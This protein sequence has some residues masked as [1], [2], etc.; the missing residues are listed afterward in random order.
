MN[1]KDLRIGNLVYYFDKI[2]EI[3]SLHPQNDDVNDEIPFHCISGIPITTEWL[4][5]LGFIKE[6]YVNNFY[7]ENDRT[8]YLIYLEKYLEGEDDYVSIEYLKIPLRQKIKIKYVHQ[9]QNLFYSIR[10]YELSVS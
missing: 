8:L 2:I 1:P 10:N 5:K 3:E 9:L 7:L 4:I 6:N